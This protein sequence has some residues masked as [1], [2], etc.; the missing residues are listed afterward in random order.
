MLFKN[1]KLY[2]FFIVLF[3]V[4]IPTFMIYQTFSKS[5]MDFS[6]IGNGFLSSVPVFKS[7]IFTDDGKHFVYTYNDEVEMPDVKGSVQLRGFSY[8]SYFQVINTATG[9]KDKNPIY[10]TSK[11]AQMY[12]LWSEG[13]AVW[14]LKN[15]S[16]G[17]NELALYDIT[18]RKFVFEFG[19][20][21]KLNASILSSGAEFFYI[22]STD[23]KGLIIE[24]N[25]KR[26]YRINPTTGIAELVQG[27]FEGLYS[28]NLSSDFNLSKRS[29]IIDYT[30]ENIN[31]NRESI[32]TKDRN[33][34]LISQDDFIDVNFL[35]LDKNKNILNNVSLT[36]YNHNFF[37]LTRKTTKSNQEQELYM[38]NKNTLKTEWKLYLP[39]KKL[40]TIIPRY[41]NERFCIKGEK[42]FITNNNYFLTVDLNSGEIVKKVNLY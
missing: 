40:K 38:L 12:V 7:G 29:E 39:Q 3:A 18:T 10:E 32:T 21:E 2:L 26:F 23:E 27:K 35:T 6:K 19:K 15:E 25:D 1:L 22:N 8:P 14:L 9:K 36:Y 5:G 37:V 17:K 24:G 11:G 41:Y 16:G 42:M 34:K 4:G 31:G 13:N 30:T 33:N 28:Y 20:I